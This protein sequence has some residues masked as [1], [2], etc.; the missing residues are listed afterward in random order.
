MP[1]GWLE[2][3]KHDDGDIFNFFGKLLIHPSISSSYEMLSPFKTNTTPSKLFYT[4]TQTG[5]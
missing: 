1:E 4:V 3:P 2:N 5:S